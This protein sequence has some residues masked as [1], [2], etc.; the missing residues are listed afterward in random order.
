MA[1]ILVVSEREQRCCLLGRSHGDSPERSTRPGVTPHLLWG[2]AVVKWRVGEVLQ[3]WGNSIFQLLCLPKQIKSKN[4]ALHETLF[5]NKK[6]QL[7]GEQVVTQADFRML[8]CPLCY[9]WVGTHGNTGWILQSDNLSGNVYYSESKISGLAFNPSYH[10]AKIWSWE[11]HY[12]WKSDTLGFK[13][14]LYT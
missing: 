8:Q 1:Q 4:V 11:S 9:T 5:K 12:G 10:R 7:S 13:F 14:C 2:I 6:C 3:L